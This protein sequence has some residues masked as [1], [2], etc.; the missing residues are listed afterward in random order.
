VTCASTINDQ[1]ARFNAAWA[2]GDP[3]AVVEL[4]SR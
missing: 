2:T 3:D 4:F 1:F